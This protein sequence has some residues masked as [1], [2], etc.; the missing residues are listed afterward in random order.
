MRCTC[1]AH[2]AHAAPQSPRLSSQSRYPL[3]RSLKCCLYSHLMQVRRRRAPKARSQRWAA[4]PRQS[5]GTRDSNGNSLCATAAASCICGSEALQVS[6]L[7]NQRL[8]KAP[9]A[10]QS[11]APCNKLSSLF[12]I[13]CRDKS[14]PGLPA[15]A[16]TRTSFFWA[17][18]FMAQRGT[19]RST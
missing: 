4:I 10:H 3:Q 6:P 5:S 18:M 19:P 14:F 11:A 1:G 15:M 12:S 17:K 9:E 8:T 7:R 16:R 2:A 13:P